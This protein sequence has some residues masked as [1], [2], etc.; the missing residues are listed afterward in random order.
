MMDEK[1][2]LQL[3]F[4]QCDHLE[5]LIEELEEKEKVDDGRKPN[6]DNNIKSS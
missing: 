6:T 4:D 2:F 5:E 1:K 3:I